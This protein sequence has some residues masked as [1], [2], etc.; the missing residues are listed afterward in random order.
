MLYPP[1]VFLSTFLKSNAYFWQVSQCNGIM[2]RREGMGE[3]KKKSSNISNY[4]MHKQKHMECSCY[5]CVNMEKMSSVQM[6]D[7][8]Y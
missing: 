4:M 6:S 2:S 5:P 7:S 1:S 3:K 8:V